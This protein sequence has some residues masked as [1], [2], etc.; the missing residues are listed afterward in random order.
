MSDPASESHREALYAAFADR[1][2]PVEDAV[3]RALAIG[4]ERLDVSIGFFTRIEA[5]TQRIEIV[6]GD[7]D[8]LS[9]GTEC[10]LD[11]AYCRRTIELEGP[12]SVQH[13]ETSAA[14]PTEAYDRFGIDTYLGCNLMVR[15]SVVGTVC[16]ADDDP[17]AEPFDERAET[18]VELLAQ[19]TGQA[20]ERE[21]YEAELTAR[22]TDLETERRRLEAIAENSF[23]VLYVL[24]ADGTFEYVSPSVEGMLG[25]EP[26]AL[27]G[28]HFAE[29]LDDSS[30]P[31]ATAAFDQLL[32]GDSL[33]AIDVQFKRADG[34]T[35]PLEF[36][37]GPVVVDGEVVAIQ[38]VARDVSR[39]QDRERELRLKNRVV[40]QSAIG[41]T[42]ADATTD[43]LAIE[44]ANDT[45]CAMTEYDR[46]IVV[47]QPLFFYQ[48]PATDQEPLADIEAASL[49]GRPITREFVGF[50]ESGRPFWDQVTAMP[51]EADSGELG[52]VV[53]FHQDVTEDKRTE[54]LL[55]ILNRVLRHNIRNDMT[56]VMG[57]ADVLADHSDPDDG[58]AANLIAAGEDLITIAENARDLEQFASRSIEPTLYEPAALLTT[59]ESQ[60]EA[61]EQSLSIEVDVDTEELIV[62][63]PQLE[64]A[65]CELVENAVEHGDAGPTNVW[66]SASAADGE[67]VI[68][69][70]DDGPGID[71]ADAAVI[72]AGTETDLVH[73]LGLGLW[74]VDWIVTKYG[75]SFRI[76]P[77]DQADKQ[78]TIATIRLPAVPPETTLSAVDIKPTTLFW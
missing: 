8:V 48:G 68:T 7:H 15:G 65:L 22:E 29:L 16:F 36:N 66:L 70:R 12:L 76:A 71:P 45:F 77:I 17:R 35:V 41:V 5:D 72:D 26:S 52:H 2:V 59:L 63:G 19:L 28:R 25:Y 62:A 56:V 14:V 78:G 27:L 18:F 55:D 53:C 54:N 64:R 61:A 49:D 23:D 13:A 46:E 74:I 50:R 47:G 75:G 58:P 43:T 30:I 67:S 44:Y 33:Q 31:E 40:D 10:P 20:L 32:A 1:T 24:D 38:G 21:A 39:R 51:I 3:E 37:G 69:V 60:F 11:E 42:I 73:N 34:E 6:V 9:V 4:T 57:Y